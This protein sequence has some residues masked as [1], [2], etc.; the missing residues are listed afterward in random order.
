VRRTDYGEGKGHPGTTLTD[1]QRNW[2]TPQARDC[3]G[4]F[5]AH[6]Q[7]GDDLSRQAQTRPQSDG[8]SGV[9]NPAFV[10]IL[11]GL[12]IGWTDCTRSVTA[13]CH[14]KP[15]SRGESSGSD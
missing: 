12:P 2:A 11:Q 3:K 13:S 15:R 1:A 14:S 5:T 9:L 7:G 4:A 10:E 6:R 8:Q